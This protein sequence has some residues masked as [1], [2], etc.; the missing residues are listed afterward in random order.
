MIR[1]FVAAFIALLPI[2]AFAQAAGPETL[3]D[4]STHR[5]QTAPGVNLFVRDGGSGPALILL[6]GWPQHGLMWHT[7]A[8]SLAKDFRVIV[9]DLRGAGNSSIPQD[10]Y[11]KVTMAADIIAVMDALEIE[12]AHVAGY[13]LGSGV[14]YALAAG[15]RDRVERLAV[16]EF[17][18]PGFGYESLMA[19][20]PQ[21]DNGANWHLGLFTLPDVAEMAFGG[22]EREL[23][24]WFFWHI[25]HD[26]E[27]VSPEHF[28]AYVRSIQ[29]PGALRAGFLYY[30]AVWQ[31]AEDNKALAADPL[32]IPVLGIGGAMSAGPYVEQLF[33]PVA[34]NVTGAVIPQAGHW[35]GDENPEELAQVL[36]E[37]FSGR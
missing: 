8:P 29:R 26:G 21:W 34:T 9:P 28:E 12:T 4:F 2:S 14:A 19:P 32:T 5:V 15:H 23:L 13:D 27:A 16:M 24:S 25:A 7:V 22:K 3:D 10:G 17:G 11:D 31:D 33:K 36:L 30:A 20:T 1:L 35:L 18:L 37:F 6:H